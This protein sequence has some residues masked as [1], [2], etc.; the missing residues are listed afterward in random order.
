VSL[1]ELDEPTAGSVLAKAQARCT[2]SKAT[3]GDVRV[4]ITPD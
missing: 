3:R 4:Q 2:Y 1:T